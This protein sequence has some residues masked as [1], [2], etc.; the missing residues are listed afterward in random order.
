M[1]DRPS[2]PT[3][4]EIVTLGMFHTLRMLRTET[5]QTLEFVIGSA[6]MHLSYLEKRGCL[7]AARIMREAME[8]AMERAA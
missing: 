2:P 5:G 8:K 7:V 6:G 1:T 4:V 3:S